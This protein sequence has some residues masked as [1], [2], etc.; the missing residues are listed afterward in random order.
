LAEL[1]ELL[2]A[3]DTELAGLLADADTET[4]LLAGIYNLLA[5]ILDGYY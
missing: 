2:V 3:E 5:D 1:V 4:Y